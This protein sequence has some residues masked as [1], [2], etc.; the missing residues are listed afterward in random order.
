MKS[1]SRFIKG[2]LTGLM[3][4]MILSLGVPFLLP[5]GSP[6]AVK[7]AYA[8]LD[9]CS[10]TD[11][12][13]NIREVPAE[14]K[15]PS[16][17][18]PGSG[19]G[20][21]SG[22][23]TGPKSFEERVAELPIVAETPKDAKSAGAIVGQV[24]A[25]ATKSH[26]L[27]APLINFFAFQIGNFLGTDYVYQGQMGK[28]LQKIWVVSRNL[29]NILCVFLLLWL[30]IR[31]IFDVN[32]ESKLKKS[33]IHLVLLLVVVNFSWLGTKVVLDAANVATHVVFAI[34][35]GI[36]G[37]DTAFTA[38]AVSQP[39][40]VNNNP[41]E[42]TTGSCMPT[43]IF[44]PADAGDSN[45]LYWD[46][47]NCEK[48]KKAYSNSDSS[49]AAYHL[50]GTLNGNSSPENQKFQRR[51]S[52]C[53]EN[54]NLF[55]YDQNTAVI[56]LTYGSARIQ[57]LV[58]SNASTDIVQLSVGVLLSLIIQI[59]YSV[60]LLALFIALIIRMAALWMFVGF[61]PLLCLI[62][63]FTKED[64]KTASAL[65]GKF[66]V[67]SFLK[68][69]FVPVKVGAV[70]AVSFIMISAGQNVG[71]AN[72][73]LVDN[74]NTQ[75]GVSAHILDPQ[76]L[77]MGI[78]SLQTF[79][80][81]IMSVV[82]LWM[83]VFAV[84]GEM[85]IV[86]NIT[87]KIKAYGTGLAS[88]VAKTPYM[89]PILPLGKGGEAT[90]IQSVV[91]GVDLKDKL[92]S[93]YKNVENQ[94]EDVRTLNSN[95]SSEK[96]KRQVDSAIKS[97]FTLTSAQ[98]NQFASAFGLSLNRFLQ[99]DR[100]AAEKAIKQAG[101]DESQTGKIYDAIKKASTESPEQIKERI[102]QEESAKAALPGGRPAVTGGG[103][104]ATPS[105]PPPKK[106]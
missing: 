100:P 84:L 57:N 92:N 9:P 89:A 39:C 46:S 64:I 61:S 71:A 93:R 43:H 60:S 27:F 81:L 80:W 56:Y 101:A 25:L 16:V 94:P 73:T 63:Y 78:G 22:S 23:S 37:G 98:A 11:E 53:M 74:V 41:Q 42:P 103:A 38:E 21:G 17:H 82:V 72:T 68:W 95:A 33:L 97:N 88:V 86:K 24:A 28:M 12:N 59:A 96:A 19:G 18:D 35:S 85:E 2:I 69:A 58:N 13:G 67:D 20:S 62:F 40:V 45:V 104:S 1:H 6:L 77:F 99:L 5:S 75:S 66:D 49:K 29:V 52:M 90:S 14:C 50:D 7:Q 3:V 102:A 48:V 91:A 8:D 30:A 54:L 31:E 106:Q 34:P 44:A 51:T 4:A 26:R 10:Q 55:K 32:S 70:F 79:I 105:A 65:S 36:S 87:D 76:S 15:D 83:G 47:A